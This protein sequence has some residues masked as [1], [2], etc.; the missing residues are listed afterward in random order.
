MSLSARFGT[1]LARLITL[2]P[3][4]AIGVAVSGGGDSM[5]LLDLAHAWCKGR[6]IGLHSATVN[7]GLRPEAA[8]EADMVAAFCASR[9]ISHDTIRWTGW[10]GK[11]NLQAA[12]RNARR[13]LLADWA[14]S[15]GLKAILV[16]HTADDQ[17]ET[18][19]MR[20]A[21]GSGV[22][23][24]AGIPARTGGDI[25]F[26]RPLMGLGRTE[27]RDYLI[28]EGIAW[29]DDPSNDDDAFDRVRARKMMSTLADL[30]LTQ[31]RLL[32]TAEHM[33][34]AQKVLKAEALRR[35]KQDVTTDG[36]DL[37]LAR[38]LLDMEASDTEPRLLAAA[39]GWVGGEAAY[40]PRFA[41]LKDAAEAVL[42]GQTRTIGGVILSPQAGGKVRLTREAAAVAGLQTEVDPENAPEAGYIWDGRWRLLPTAPQSRLPAGLKIRALGNGV[43][44]C[45][46][47]RASGLP[48]ASLAATPA[49][50]SDNR[51]ESAPMAGFLNG[52]TAIIAQDFLSW[53]VT[54]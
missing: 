43:L 10:D 9:G 26:L 47:W 23:G 50:W 13:G 24:L 41:S 42:A 37:V 28:A 4:D 25:P 11:G 19:L 27:L 35:A 7:H 40:K 17:A 38:S 49:I 30:G 52:W 2:N 44:S 46:D 39:I 12:A 15:Q 16:G 54:H 29:V 21:R 6:K 1:A 22:D 36:G 32:Q 48:R 3:G 45:P 18:V 34:A 51:L 33:Q 53:L 31:E 14:A 8:G 20:L 5:A